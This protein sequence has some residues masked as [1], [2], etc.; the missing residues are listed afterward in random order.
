MIIDTVQEIA[1]AR[2]RGT[3]A[4]VGIM[5][6]IMTDRRSLSGSVTEDDLLAAGFTRVEVATHSARARDQAAARDTERSD[7]DHPHSALAADLIEVSTGLKR[8]ETRNAAEI[9]RLQAGLGR[10]AARVGQEAGSGEAAT[11]RHP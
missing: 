5:A 10:I 4:L 11:G 7:R 3:N 1:N 2:A 6:R 8:L 9:A